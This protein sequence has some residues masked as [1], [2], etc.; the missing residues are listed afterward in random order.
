MFV[1]LF[2]MVADMGGDPE[3]FFS[4]VSKALL[5]LA[6]DYPLPAFPPDVEEGTRDVAQQIIRAVMANASPLAAH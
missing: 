1:T 5:E 6:R 3:G 4:E 2:R